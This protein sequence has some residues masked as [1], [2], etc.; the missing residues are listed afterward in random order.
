M[1]RFLE[2]AIP[3][4]LMIHVGFIT[5]QLLD[6]YAF[7]PETTGQSPDYSVGFFSAGQ[8][9]MPTPDG[10]QTP[11]GSNLET[12]LNRQRGLDQL[13]DEAMDDGRYTDSELLY[14]ER[15][16][17]PDNEEEYVESTVSFLLSLICRVKELGAAFVFFYSLLVLD[18][19]FVAQFEQEGGVILWII[20]AFQYAGIITGLLF[21]LYLAILFV[22]S[23][24]IG[25]LLTPRG[26]LISGGLAVAGRI[27][28]S[29]LANLIQCG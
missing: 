6:S 20:D 8:E 27:G 25:A 2:R 13:L 18:Y 14:P 26:V 24:L 22:R 7:N 19:P 28:S 11:D 21:L 12:R 3:I 4:W 15:Y 23:G 9:A 10:P 5:Y 1:E 29:A 17:G 16:R